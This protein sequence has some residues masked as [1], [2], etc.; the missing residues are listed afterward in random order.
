MPEPKHLDFITYLLGEKIL[1]LLT[2]I[3]HIESS[4]FTNDNVNEELKLILD[5]IVLSNLD[6]KQFEQ[7]LL[8]KNKK[9]KNKQSEPKDKKTRK[10][11]EY[12]TSCRCQARVWGPIYIHGK[13]KTYGHQCLKKKGND[14]NYCF[15]HQTKLSHGDYFKEPNIMIK[16]HFEINSTIV[17]QRSPNNKKVT[18]NKSTKNNK[19]IKN[20]KSIKINKA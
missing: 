3:S 1:D 12:D 19:I 5:N 8:N 15:I 10:K 20:T 11:I 13:Q 9:N 14:S 7:L 6:S 4:L 18:D 17:K 16:E 2:A